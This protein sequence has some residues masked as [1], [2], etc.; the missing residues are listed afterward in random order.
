MGCR[1]EITFLARRLAEV[2]KD[3]ALVLLNSRFNALAGK[4]GIRIDMSL[5]ARLTRTTPPLIN[6]SAGPWVLGKN[7]MALCKLF[8]VPVPALKSRRDLPQGLKFLVTYSGSRF[9]LAIYE[10]KPR[11][12]KP[13]ILL[14]VPESGGRG[15]SE[16]RDWRSQARPIHI[17]PNRS[18]QE[19]CVY[20]SLRG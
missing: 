13:H 18:H 9:F 2:H 6:V 19:W 17:K 5:L 12:A 16:Q 3:P 20:L 4:V 7:L 1:R 10:H 15:A 14:L 8:S 11:P